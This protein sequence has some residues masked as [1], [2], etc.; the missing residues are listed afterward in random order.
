[1]KKFR[2]FRQWRNPYTPYCS[3]S[4]DSLFSRLIGLGNKLKTEDYYSD[5]LQDVPAGLTF[6]NKIMFLS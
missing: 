3:S 2:N 6:F 4:V 5:S 1:M